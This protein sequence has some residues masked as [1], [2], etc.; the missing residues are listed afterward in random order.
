M[1]ARDASKEGEVISR[2]RPIDAHQDGA[3]D[4]RD[5][6]LSKPWKQQASCNG[7]IRVEEHDLHGHGGK[8]L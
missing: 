5:T 3:I 4:E 7:G 1:R 6:K 8:Y 2:K